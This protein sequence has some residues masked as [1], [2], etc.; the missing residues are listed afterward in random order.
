MSLSMMFFIF[1]T[2]LILN[3][4]MF[5]LEWM[6]MS[7]NSTCIYMS[8]ILDWM[9]MI[10]V[11]FVFGISSVVIFYSGE[12]MNLDLNI[13]RFIYL[14]M[15]FILSMMFLIISPNM[16]SILL[17]WD[18]LGL[19]SYCLVIY[20]QNY[21]SYN[22]GMLTSLM[23]RI[24]DVAI[25]MSIAWMMNFGSWHYLFFLSKMNNFY[26]IPFMIILASFTKSAQLPFSSWLPAA[27]AAPTPVSSLVHSSTLVTAGVYL[28]IRFNLLIYNFFL[29]DFFLILSMLTM[30]MSSIGAN[31]EYDLKKIIALSTLSQLGFMMSIL[32]IGFPTM[33]F[34]HLL[35]HALFK[36]LLFLCAGMIIHCMWGN[37]DIR[38][39]GGLI[40]QLPIVTSCLNISNL[41]LCG[42]P[43]LAGFY[44]KDLIM[45]FMMMSNISLLYYILLLISIGLTVMYSF[46]LSYYCLS[47]SPNLFSY[48]SIYDCSNMMK[49]SILFMVMFSIF[50]GSFMSWLMF[51]TP[52]LVYLPFDLKIITIILVFSGALIGY[53]LNYY[54]TK[55]FGNMV[56][57]NFFFGS[58]WFMPMFSTFFITNNSLLL[59][60]NYYKL[61]D[62]GWNEHWGPMGLT[63]FLVYLSKFNQMIQ[64][65]NLK[66]YMIVF[67]IW[68]MFMF[69]LV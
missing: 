26:F 57:V 33:A 48:L 27:M 60:I 64:I 9:S 50:G 38:F 6:I 21:K 41:A 15:M 34:F 24:G 40:I 1:C 56:L 28:L 35:I 69:I 53:E 13:N 29:I 30:I 23:N 10:F 44:S 22:A 68:M 62:Q 39:M 18:G 4:K 14:V 17:G 32:M 12:Y 49:K 65:N 59:S 2:Y 43:F 47:S 3:D 55:I 5:M 25:L 20:Y 45:E 67:I 37:Q 66:I 58:M 61:I 51:S 36:A 11:S 7:M 8:I 31:F 16:V 19:V 63:S 46:R 54:F 42:F 52:C